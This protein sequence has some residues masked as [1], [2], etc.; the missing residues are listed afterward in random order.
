MI[1][2]MTGFSVYACVSPSLC[3]FHSSFLLC[4]KV[5]SLK[6]YAKDNFK[7]MDIWCSFASLSLSLCLFWAVCFSVFLC[8]YLSSLCLQYWL[9]HLMPTFPI[10]ISSYLFSFF[11]PLSLSHLAAHSSLVLTHPP[12]ISDFSYFFDL[13]WLLQ[14]LFSATIGALDRRQKHKMDI[15]GVN[16]D[17]MNWSYLITSN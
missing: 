17:D 11:F 15:V 5:S 10:C 13:L 6:T 3:V 16:I 9:K 8:H 4:S 7:N 14:A 1:P 2:P 12:P